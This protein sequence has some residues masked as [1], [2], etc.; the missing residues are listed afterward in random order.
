MLSCLTIAGSVAWLLEFDVLAIVSLFV[1][2]LVVG[3]STWV[4]T[5]VAVVAVAALIGK[6][7]AGTILGK[8]VEGL[9]EVVEG[10]TVFIGD[11]KTIST[12]FFFSATGSTT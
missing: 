11:V 7:L 3:R 8:V 5:I 12:E 2:I 6:L 1:A 4:F 10:V 9:D